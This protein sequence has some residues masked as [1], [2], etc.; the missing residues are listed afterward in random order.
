MLKIDFTSEAI[1]Q[2][3]YERYHHPHPRVQRKMNVLY[4]KSQN[5]SHK[6]I[7]RLE[8]ICE[9]T[10]LRYL[11]E[12]QEGGIERLKEIHFYA[13]KSKLDEYATSIES[14]FNE[15]P[16]ASINE[17]SAK[18]EEITG[19]KRK[20]ES[21]R[22]FMKRLGF[23]PRKVGMIP[24]KADVEQQERFLTEELK[25][26]LAEAQAGKRSLF[27][28]DAAHFVLAPFL[29]IL[30]SIVRIFIKA[31]SGRKRF[32]VLGALNAI[33]HSFIMVT[34]DSYINSDSVCELLLK[35]AECS[36]GIPITIVLD[37]ARY[38][39]CKKVED[40]A[41]YLG[42]EL[43]FLPPYSPNLNLIERVWKFVKRKCLYSKYYEKFSEFST[44][45]S[46]CLE[47]LETTH[48]AEVSTL[49]SL[50]FQTFEKVRVIGG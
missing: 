46:E 9:N 12:Y 7:K 44:A 21:T 49:L 34:N 1:T 39:R 22:V 28:V 8:R 32:N 13:P 10:L 33:T 16:P 38:Q 26:R 2:L 35:I 25:P 42:I 3:N 45:I 36:T 37:N 4:L 17:A 30:W 27:F 48:K 20:R 24:A 50:N 5:I 18:I 40:Y 23:N 6:E 11:R 29:G 14:Y 15:H 31:P 19:I 41:K 43:L 47:K